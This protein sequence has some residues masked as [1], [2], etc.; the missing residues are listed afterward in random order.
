MPTEVVRFMSENVRRD[1]SRQSGGSGL[2]STNSSAVILGLY[3]DRKSL[4]APVTSQASLSE[5]ERSVCNGLR[6]G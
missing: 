3:E 1:C 2:V 4:A 6:V 5:L